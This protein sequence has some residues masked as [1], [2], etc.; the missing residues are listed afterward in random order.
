MSIYTR[1]IRPLLFQLQPETAHRV[2]LRALS[3]AGHVPLGMRGLAACL[4]WADARLETEVL[5][6]RFHNPLG[7]AA[8]YDKDGVAIRELAALGFGHVEVGTVSPLVQPG[9]AAP[10]VFRLPQEEAVINRMGF[11]NLGGDAMLPCLVRARQRPLRTVLGVSIGKGRATPLEAAAQDYCHLVRLLGRHAS[12]LAVNVSSPNT[13]NLR[14]LQARE[15]LGALLREIMPCRDAHCP[16][17]PVLVKIAPD[18]TYAEIDDVLAAVE[19][20]RVDGI[21]ATNTGLGRSGPSCGH[22]LAAEYGGLSGIPLR[23]RSTEVIRYIYRQTGGAVPIIG[24]GGVDSAES[25]LEKLQA[26]ASLVQVYTGLIYQGPALVRVI[27]QGLVRRMEEM[28]V[29]RV[30]ELVGT[31][32]QA[33]PARRRTP[34]G[35]RIPQVTG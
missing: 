26:G 14:R 30:A 7:L 23:Q 25:A 32:G 16:G 28:G 34:V 15:M 5:G 17:V 2:A 18:L 21:V 29:R 13:A 10:R 3:A 8:G 12:Y 27:N 11:P 9:N 31:E 6:L 22:P 33:A 1:L 4:D 24:V 35:S 20:S 19:T